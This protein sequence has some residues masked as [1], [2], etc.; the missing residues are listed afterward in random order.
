MLG[1]RGCCTSH[2]HSVFCWQHC[3]MNTSLVDL[4]LYNNIKHPI[5]G[6][7]I[8]LNSFEPVNGLCSPD[9]LYKQ[10]YSRGSVSV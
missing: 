9:S 5:I 3:I 6:F 1:Y 10:L 7:R 4:R 2:S 8:Y